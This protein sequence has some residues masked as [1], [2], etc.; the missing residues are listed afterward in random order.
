MVP[1]FRK[2]P[3]AADSLR[4]FIYGDTPAEKWL[5]NDSEAEPWASFR[6]ARD[7]A[8]AGQADEAAAIWQ[9]IAATEG[10]ESRQTLQAWHFLRQ[11]GHQAPA[12]QARLALGAVAEMPMT[13][14]HD[15]LAAYRDGTARYLN[16]S[17]KV[18]IWEDRSVAP[19]QAAIADCLTAAQAIADVVGTWD[20]PS[21]PPVGAGLVRVMALTPGG[22]RFGMGRYAD[23]S[24]DPMAG[25]FLTAAGV[26]LREIVARAAD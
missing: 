25:R 8:A 16:F 18:A 17:G 20:E 3:S 5:A 21:I 1:I 13:S 9:R 2:H 12:N 15:L 10:L 14:G 7:L 22:P 6:R 24:A 23:L 11:A 19:V 26:L 4:P